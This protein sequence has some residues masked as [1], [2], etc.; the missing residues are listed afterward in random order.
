PGCHLIRPEALT[1]PGA[2]NDIGG[3]A[4]DLAGIAKNAIFAECADRALGEHV[5][6]AGDADQ[7]ADPSNAGD[8]RFVPFFEVDA[9]TAGQESGRL[10]HPLDMRFELE[11]IAFRLGCSTDQ[12]TQ[13]A[14]VTQDPI[15]RAM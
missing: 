3:A 7:F 4:Y 10:P 6:A 8:E 13:P 5:V 11:C 15:D 9:W 1:A 2:E 14:H 12:C